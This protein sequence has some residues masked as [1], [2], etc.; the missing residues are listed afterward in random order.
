MIVTDLNHIEEQVAM[1]DALRRAIA[2]LRGA[3][4]QD[5]AEGRVELGDALYARVMPYVTRSIDAD[6]TVEGHKQYI[7][8]HYLVSGEEILACAAT[9]RVQETRPYDAAGD[10]WLG[11]L[12]GR[13]AHL[14]HLRAG[15][16]AVLYPAD[17][18]A[19][20]LVAG[21][22]TPVKKIVVKVPLGG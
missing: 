15:D 12:P 19:P 16:I 22:A 8:V 10:V 17:L 14:I 3:Q 6:L 4:H 18:H 9:G 20:G 2:F 7:D 13:E 1:T 5:L 11:T 21:A